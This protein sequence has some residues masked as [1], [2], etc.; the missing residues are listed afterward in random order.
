MK[1]KKDVL[2]MNKYKK[3]EFLF[4]Q[5][6]K[7]MEVLKTVVFFGVS[8]IL[9]IAGIVCKPPNVS[10]KVKKKSKHKNDN[11]CN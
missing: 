2:V 11:F 4:F 1:I 8:A 7:K 3:G 5:N 10:R 9:Y 6:K